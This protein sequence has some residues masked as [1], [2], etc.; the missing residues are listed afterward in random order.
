[1]FFRKN[2][3]DNRKKKDVCMHGL[4]DYLSISIPEQNCGNIFLKTFQKPKKQNNPF[5]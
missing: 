2:S 3:G 1:M 5:T 4:F